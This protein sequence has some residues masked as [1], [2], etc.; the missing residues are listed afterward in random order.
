[1]VINIF[2][3]KRAT[4]QHLGSTFAL[5]QDNWN[6]FSFRTLYH[7]YYQP[8][9]SKPATLIGP[10]KILRRGQTAS[11]STQI[12]EPFEQLTPDFCSVGNSLDYYQ[13]LSEIPVP[14]RDSIVSALRD[15]VAT[16][17]L[18]DEFSQE[19]GWR[20]SLFRENSDHAG[21][22]ADA[23]AIYSN[24]YAALADL[25]GSLV[26]RPTGWTSPLILNFDAPEPML[27]MGPRRP[28]GPSRTRVLLPRRIIVVIGRNGS[29][30]ST[31][32]SRMARVAFASPSER[33][34]PT[35]RTIGEFEPASI[36][37]TRIIAISYSAFDNFILPGVYD[38]DLRQIAADVEKGSGRYVYAGLRDVVREARDDAD[39]V[40]AKPAPT[41]DRQIVSV[42]DRRTTTKLK[43]LNDLADE[44]TRLVEQIDRQGDGPLLDAALAPLLADQ[45]FIDLEGSTRS[46]LF[47]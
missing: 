28:I 2:P 17:A 4:P 5:Q 1:M 27:Y 11:D 10:V 15:V 30:K 24:S 18:Q 6:D 31:L 21:Y 47:R 29:G 42:E 32:L 14:D 19:E 33:T 35:I 23:T 36:G 25:S 22:L 7:L 16:P 46:D 37:F 44:F 40:D 43:S 41:E 12:K 8:D 38:S 34:L 39:A 13:R 20:V 9:D 3:P 26:F 45:S